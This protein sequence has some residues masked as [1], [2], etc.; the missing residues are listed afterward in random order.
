M[1]RRSYTPEEYERAA[2]RLER[3]IRDMLARNIWPVRVKRS[4]MTGDPVKVAAAVGTAC[5]FWNYRHTEPEYLFTYT[6]E[7]INELRAEDGRVIFSV[8]RRGPIV[9]SSEFHS[10]GTQS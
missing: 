6:P 2:S 1:A 9:S 3:T 8:L 4:C 7:P 5:V 10:Q